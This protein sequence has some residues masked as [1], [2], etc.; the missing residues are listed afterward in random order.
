MIICKPLLSVT[1]ESVAYLDRVHFRL[2]PYEL[3]NQLALFFVL[4]ITKRYVTIAQSHI[5]SLKM[6]DSNI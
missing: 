3:D 2:E 6:N 5:N 4:K 1:V